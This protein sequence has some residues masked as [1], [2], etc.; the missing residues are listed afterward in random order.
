MDQLRENCRCNLV[1]RIGIFRVVTQLQIRHVLYG[2]IVRRMQCR[3]LPRMH[4][5][6]PKDGVQIAAKATSVR[7]ER[8]ECSNEEGSGY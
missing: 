4:C 6:D 5:F 1:R 8:H 7:N 3:I 2:D